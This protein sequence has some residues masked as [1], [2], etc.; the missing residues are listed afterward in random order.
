MALNGVMAVI[1]RHSTELI[2]LGAKY[3][4]VV[5]DR[6]RCQRKERRLVQKN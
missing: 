4:K 1:L 5:E 3:V 2:S 6:L